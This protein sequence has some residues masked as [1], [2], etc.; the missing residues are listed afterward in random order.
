VNSTYFIVIKVS[1][2]QK[3]A[4]HFSQEAIFRQSPYQ[5]QQGTCDEQYNA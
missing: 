1:Y 5:I 2:L 3:I 4:T